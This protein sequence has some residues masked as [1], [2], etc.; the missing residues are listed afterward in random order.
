MDYMKSYFSKII[1]D[2]DTVAD[3]V[4]MK[5]DEL[6]TCLANVLPFEKDKK[7]SV[8]DLGSGTGHGM[9]LILERFQNA[10]VTGIDFSK[11]MIQIS[12]EKLKPFG[13]RVKLIDQDFRD[14]IFSESYNTMVSAIAIHNI[15]HQQKEFLFQKIF[16]ALK[17]GG[18]FVNA[19]FIEGESKD[20]HE[21]YRQ[22]YSKYMQEHLS[23]EEL[24]VWLHHAF[25]EDMPMKL[26]E[27]FS[28]LKKI[29]FKD[30]TLHWQFGME[31]VYSARK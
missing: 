12:T 4:V 6:H 5:N 30:I 18:I 24:T 13:E 14:S 29:G 2:Y 3:A 15:T 20:I 16:N 7:I 11:K 10:K 28:L 1:D 17:D 27:Q 8:L 23:G 26:T 31:A 9:S 21:H 19:D 25:V 22:I